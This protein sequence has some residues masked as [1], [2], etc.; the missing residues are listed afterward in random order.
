[1][2]AALLASSTLVTWPMVLVC[3]PK[4]ISNLSCYCGLH[5]ILMHSF[6][7]SPD[8]DGDGELGERH[9]SMYGC[10]IDHIRCFRTCVRRSSSIHLRNQGAT[11]GLKDEE[12]IESLL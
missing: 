1:S 6:S 4:M 8:V 5:L 12:R 10:R 9:P 7:S 11:H 2:A 3:Y